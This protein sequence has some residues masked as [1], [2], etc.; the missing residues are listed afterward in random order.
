MIP[1]PFDIFK[2][3]NP[4]RVQALIGAGRTAARCGEGSWRVGIVEIPKKPETPCVLWGGSKNKSGYGFFSIR[5]DTFAAHRIEWER[6]NGEIPDGLEMDHLC[7]NPSCVNPDHLEA[8]TSRV[9]VLRSTCPPAVNARKT[10]CIRGHE[11]DRTNKRGQRRCCKCRNI[12]WA[13]KYIHHPL[14]PKTHCSRGHEFTEKNTRLGREG[15]KVCRKCHSFSV[16]AEKKARRLGL[17]PQ[18]RNK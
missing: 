14:P 12:V 13:E 10:H 3:A 11:F 6:V 5:G 18:R 9:N 1:L 15:W 7:R 17:L 4:H 16:R 2:E 8:V